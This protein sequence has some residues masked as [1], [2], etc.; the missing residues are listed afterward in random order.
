MSD[1]KILEYIP[2]SL[3]EDLIEEVSEILKERAEKGPS[4]EEVLKAIDDWVKSKDAEKQ[5]QKK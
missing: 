4:K 3:R 5:N 2:E 1:K